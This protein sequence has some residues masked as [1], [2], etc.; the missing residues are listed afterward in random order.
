MEKQG[1]TLI[2]LLV[3]IAIIGILAAILLPALARARE[4]ARR[5][6]CAN[7]LKQMGVVFKMYSNEAPGGKFPPASFAARRG[8]EL[9]F[10]PFVV[11]PEYLTDVKVLVCP[12]DARAT[13]AELQETFDD[14]QAGDPN[15]RWPFLDLANDAN[16]R[17]FV[18]WHLFERAYS[19]AYFPWATSDTNTFYALRKRFGAEI[20]NNP[21]RCNAWVPCFSLDWDINIPANLLGQPMPNPQPWFPPEELP[22]MTG[23]SGGREIYRLKEGIERFFITDINNPAGSAQAQSNIIL[24]MDVFQAAQKAQGNTVANRTARFNHLPGGSNILYM[25]GHVEFVKYP[26]KYP[27]SLYVAG[28]YLDG[29][30]GTDLPSGVLG[31]YRPEIRY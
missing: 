13:A 11:F 16:M 9:R 26:G 14:I 31:F 12:S 19:Y 7:N 28:S 10:S 22:L 17:K 5:S 15:Q 3:V 21:S 2:E 25:D 18:T 27:M 29:G 4:A 20:W 24:D 23:S 1:F 6:S 8:R 30:Q